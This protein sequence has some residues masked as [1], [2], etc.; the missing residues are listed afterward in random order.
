MEIIVPREV[1]NDLF[2][3][4]LVTNY[5]TVTTTGALPG[6]FLALFHRSPEGMPG[7]LPLNQGKHNQDRLTS[8]YRQNLVPH[9]LIGP[10]ASRISVCVSQYRVL[11]V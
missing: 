10:S 6:P 8:F 11:E 7:D 2:Q 5:H 9:R 1:R 4:I 3:P